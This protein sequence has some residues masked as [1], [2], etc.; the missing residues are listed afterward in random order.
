MTKQRIPNLDE[1]INESVNESLCVIANKEQVL[2]IK[3]DDLDNYSA[4]GP[5]G[6]FVH[7]RFKSNEKKKANAYAKGVAD[8][9]NLP[10]NK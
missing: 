3:S 6:Y 4:E 2:V 8:S 7:K 1:F 9:K 10:F 5:D